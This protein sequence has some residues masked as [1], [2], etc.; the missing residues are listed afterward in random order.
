M[1]G[2]FPHVLR[3]LIWNMFEVSKFDALYTD[4]WA[5][6]PAAPCLL[7]RTIKVAVRYHDLIFT[8][9]KHQRSL[10]SNMVSEMPYSV[11]SNT[12]VP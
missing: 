10:R 1:A 11:Y 6:K 4:D 9:S 7:T 5:Q 2:R 3:S 12:N 8:D